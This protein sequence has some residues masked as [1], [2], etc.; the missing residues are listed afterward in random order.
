M[1]VTEHLT[2]E[3]IETYRACASSAAEFLAAQDH[4]AACAECRAL[5]ASAVEADE[6]VLSLHSQL[7]QTIHA[8]TPEAEFH[9]PYEQLALYVD[10]KLDEVEREIADSHLSFCVDCAADLLDLRRYEEIAA[11]VKLE[12]TV[13]VNAAPDIP[14]AWQRFVALLGSFKLPL[15]A[16][17]AAAALVLLALG[18]TWLAMR[19]GDALKAGGEL[20]RAQPE[21]YPSPAPDTPS[22]RENVPS[23]SPSSTATVSASSDDN[24]N[25]TSQAPPLSTPPRSPSGIVSPDRTNAPSAAQFVALNDGGSRVSLDGRG[26]LDGLEELPPDT[27]LAVGRSL[28]SRRVETPSSLDGLAAGAGDTLMGTGAGDASFALLSPVGRIVRDTRPAFSWRPLAGAK[29]YAVSIVDSKFKPVVQSLALDDTSWTPAEPLARGAVY[30]WQVTATLADGMEVTAPI[31]PA[32]QARFRV[33]DA[34]ASDNLTQLEKTNP[35]SRLARGVAYAQAGLLEEAEAE[36][37]E[38]LKQNPRSHVARDLLRSLRRPSAQRAA[39]P[40]ARRRR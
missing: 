1:S 25:R 33:L 7:S 13:A 17:V 5:L 18:G 14:S 19:D 26:R 35:H 2:G 30:Y 3:A 21:T 20:A 11:D 12:P 34:G 29:S 28:R 38:L 27:R 23:P 32:P 24:S 15:P 4:I 10:D 37:E 36:L 39:P 22:P 6:A 40:P 16:T 31:A 9:L 8:D